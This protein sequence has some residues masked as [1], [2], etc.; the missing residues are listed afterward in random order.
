MVH[1]YQVGKVFPS[2][3]IF[4]KFLPAH[5]PH[6]PYVPCNALT[7]IIRDFSKL[8]AGDSGPSPP[9]SRGRH[10]FYLISLDLHS[11][12]LRSLREGRGL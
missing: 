12:Y 4:N 7:N 5:L 6:Q 10:S 9:L 1:P 3:P 8:G 2:S 11:F